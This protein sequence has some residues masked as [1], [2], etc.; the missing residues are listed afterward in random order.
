MVSP[1]FAGTS[2]GLTSFTGGGLSASVYMPK[3]LP[4]IAP[5]VALNVTLFEVALKAKPER[6][7]SSSSPLLVA[8]VGCHVMVSPLVVSVRTFLLFM[9]RRSM[10][11]DALTT[12]NVSLVSPFMT[13]MSL[14]RMTILRSQGVPSL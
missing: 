8:L 5:V 4:L 2:A 13:S 14:G 11:L 3:R 6:F 9:T 12:E 7:C 10:V 1:A